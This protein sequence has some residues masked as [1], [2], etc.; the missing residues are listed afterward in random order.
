MI[1]GV[2]LCA[3]LCISA[4][5]QAQAP[6]YDLGNSPQASS[7]SSGAPSSTLEQ[8]ITVLERMVDSRTQ[9]QHRLQ[10]QI[11]TMQGEIDELRGTVEVHTNQLEKVLERQ[12]EL[13]LEIDKRVEA[14]KQA[15]IGA[16]SSADPQAAYT[17]PATPAASRPT[18]SQPA[19]ST[20]SAA[21][22]DQ[23]DSDAYEAAVNLILK[24]GEYDRAIA[25]LQ[26]FLSDYPDS[27]YVPNAHYWL[28]QILFR[29]QQWD[30]AYEQFD[31]VVNQYSDSAKRPDAIFKLGMI[32]ERQGNANKAR[33]LFEQVIKEYPDSAATKLAQSRM[34]GV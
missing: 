22:N 10:Q 14:L 30:A 5:A 31:T 7:A 4:V 9:M 17:P 18:Q 3:A 1:Q 27:S 21:R 33:S 16:A 24:S 12:R 25:S 23:S 34:S 20:S 13:Y 19:A 28:G 32:A 26:S 29:E 15:G 11:D 6:V 8:R 2:T